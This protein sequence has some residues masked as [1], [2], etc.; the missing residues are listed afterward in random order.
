V[1]QDD[2]CRVLGDAEFLVVFREGSHLPDGTET[3]LLAQRIEHAI[4][5][6]GVFCHVEL[7]AVSPKYFR[8]LPA[9][10]FG[11]EL[12]ASG[13]VVYGDCEILSLI[14]EFSAA[15]IPLYDAWRLL[16]NRMIEQL[17]TAGEVAHEEKDL[18]RSYYRTVKLYLDM[19]TSLLIFLR[20]YRPTYG[21]RM[22]QLRILAATQPGSENYPFRLDEFADRVALC[23]KLKLNSRELGDESAC[24]IDLLR[25][26][27]IE[28]A[29]QLWNWEL[30]Q[31]QLATSGPARFCAW[32]G[33][34]GYESWSQWLRGWLYILRNQGWHR[35]WRQWSRWIPLCLQ[36]SPRFLIYSVGSSV[37]FRLPELRLDAPSRSRPDWARL[38]RRLPVISPESTPEACTDWQRLATD[39][40][41]NY[42]EFL[43]ATRA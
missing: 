8:Q 7:S 5:Q 2:I 31:L 3:R 11:Y 28:Y 37:F 22:E 42:R 17:E 38:R 13:Q 30:T 20:A 21:Q 40:L 35:S 15:E 43:T 27:A 10:I 39:V 33:E 23:T 9:H 6:H 29:R 18:S 34:Q 19:A 36:A 24:S 1:E 41:W 16:N 14:P 32:A 26:D 25:H 4:L 12:R